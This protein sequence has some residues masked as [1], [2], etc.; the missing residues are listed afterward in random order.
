[1][2]VTGTV[3]AFILPENTPY[4]GPASVNGPVALRYAKV[5]IV[6]DPSLIGETDATGMFSI[7]SATLSPA[8]VITVRVALERAITQPH[9]T[10]E[11]QDGASSPTLA[12][13]HNAG[14]PFLFTAANGK[15]FNNARTEADS[16]NVS[17]F[18]F[19]G[20]IADFAKSQSAFWTPVFQAPEV[21]AW[22][23][24]PPFDDDPCDVI[25]GYDGGF[26]YYGRERLCSPGVT[27]RNGA[28]S[29][30]VYHEYAHHYSQTS[31]WT[32]AALHRYV[33]EALADAMSAYFLNDPVI[34]RNAFHPGPPTDRRDI[35]ELWL[36]PVEDPEDPFHD[37]CRPHSGALWDLRQDLIASFPQ[38]GDAIAKKLFFGLLQHYHDPNRKAEHCPNMQMLGDLLTV[39]NELFNGA[40]L[41]G[42]A[43]ARHSCVVV[44]DADLSHDP[45]AI[46]PLA[47][48]VLSGRADVAVGSRY[49]SGGKVHEWPLGRRLLSRLGTQLARLLTRTRDPLSGLF[50]CRKE[51]LTGAIALKPRGF[52]LL[53][54]LLARAPEL[55]VVEQPIRFKDRSR[56]SSKLGLRQTFEFLA[57]LVSLYGFRLRHYHSPLPGPQGGHLS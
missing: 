45:E 15:A 22:T 55:R 43:L 26:M 57:Q 47:R 42:A 8:A 50:A 2:T 17:I 13:T 30:F 20:R 37:T 31:L 3:E 36:Y 7:T 1:V 40:V 12:I 41:R 35:S 44:L 54:E 51:F 56:G 27:L 28:N 49:G 24:F 9:F 39:D 29:S 6:E 23:N 32:P 52:K 18:V 10:V 5:V 48:S 25:A 38:D 4:T 53:L 16:A 11:P 21:A 46:V 34:G 14:D 19:L 33:D